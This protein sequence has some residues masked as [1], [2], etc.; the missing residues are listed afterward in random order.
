M[1]LLPAAA[2]AWG[3]GYVG[4]S[5]GCMQQCSSLGGTVY[6]VVSRQTTEVNHG[7]PTTMLASRVLVLL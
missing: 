7:N 2:I 4:T 5:R 1:G 6:L 3:E